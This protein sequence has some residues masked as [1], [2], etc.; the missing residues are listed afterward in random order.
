L[1]TIG[2]R[3]IFPVIPELI[4]SVT[5]RSL[6]EAALWGGVLATSFAVMQFLFGPILGELSDRRPILL[7]WLAVMA[8]YLLWRVRALRAPTL[9][10]RFGPSP[11]AGLAPVAGNLPS[12]RIA[13]N[14]YPSIWAYC[15]QAR[16]GRSS[17]MVR[18]SL[19]VYG[20]SFAFGQA[21]LVG[22]LIRHFGEQ[23]AAHMG[24][25]V[26]VGTLTVLGPVTSPVLVLMVIPITP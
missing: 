4:Q 2:I 1:D 18:V 3:L 11:C 20:V 25:W 16:F 21:V 9:W 12:A 7:L 19:A 24:M 26:N 23:R 10:A 15:S 22:P 5:G 17:T 13:M 6:A 8:D 14:V